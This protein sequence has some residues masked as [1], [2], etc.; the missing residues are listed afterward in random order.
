MS[1][2]RK[3]VASEVFDVRAFWYSRWFSVR[4]GS[5]S[6]TAILPSMEKRTKKNEREVSRV[7]INKRTTKTLFLNSCFVSCL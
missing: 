1:A 5:A 3:F 2:A 7:R 6:S 4:L